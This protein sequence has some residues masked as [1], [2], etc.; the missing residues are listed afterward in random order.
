MRDDDARTSAAANAESLS[1]SLDADRSRGAAFELKFLLEVPLAE[2]VL[3]WATDR[4]RPDPHGDPTADHAY[5]VT[6][7]Y[8]DTVDLDIARRTPGAGARKFRLR[9]YG[10][11]ALVWLER[12]VRRQDRVRKRRTVVPEGELARLAS[13]ASAA[14]W[15]G[16]WFHERVLDRELVPTCTIGYRRSAFFATTTEGPVRLTLDRRVRGLV[17]R[18]WS[19]P[20]L[21]G[22]TPVLAD[23]V[24]CEMKFRAAIPTLLKGLIADLRLTPSGVSKYRR[25]MET[26]GA[27]PRSLEA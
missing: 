1:P 17:H 10:S 22:A 8:L 14:P 12:K 2:R 4:L 27:V 6:T 25:L 7:T 9:R 19:V 20:G 26:L 18:E 21:A 15:D 16:L 5:D 23:F 24:I 3:R 11:E 13:P